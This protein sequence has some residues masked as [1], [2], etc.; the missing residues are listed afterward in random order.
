MRARLRPVNSIVSRYGLHAAVGILAAASIFSPGT[1]SAAL[2]RFAGWFL[3]H[4]DW[5][6][7]AVST[8][9]LLACVVAVLGPWGS[10]RLGGR[11]ERPEFSTL[12]WLA[13]L[14]AAGMG[15]GLVF[16]GAAEPL[17]FTVSPPPAGYYGGGAEP[18]TPAAIRDA[19]ALTMFHWALHAWAIY[20][21]AALAVGY[22]AFRLDKAPLPSV[23]FPGLP[24]PAKIA[25]DMIALL[26]V[27]FG[28]V[29]SLGQSGLQMGAGVARISGI[30]SL[31]GP[32]VRTLIILVMTAL[33]LAS[34]WGGLKRGI[35]PLSNLNMALAILLILFVLIAGPTMRLLSVMAEMAGAYLAQLPFLSVELRPEGSARGWT[36]DWSLTYFLWWVAWTPFVSVFIARISRGRTIREF[37]LGVVLV[38]SLVTLVWFA[39]FGG[40]AIWLQ[41][42]GGVDLGVNSFATAPAAT[43]VLLEHLPLAEIS[44]LVA[45]ALIFIF[46]VTSA[47]SGAYVMAMF[48]ARRPGSPP[49]MERL[50]WGLVLAALAIGALLADQG[51]R[52]TRAFAVVGAIPLAFLMTAQIVWAARAIWQDWRQKPDR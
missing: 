27:I 5:L 46:L 36:R 4:F 50:F 17:I 39:V 33:F 41:L 43:Y 9:A 22:M 30:D 38:P 34:A 40:T 11:N 51:Q 14:F 23:V 45:F 52:A 6:T 42:D 10:L 21:A 32:L 8:F 25:L 44:R 26:A 3:L 24:R 31:D 13:M 47:D 37:I 12:S 1:V 2:Q 29:A 7:L 20:A 49:R 48:S 15:A 28:V 18:Q 16:W 19:Y 35:E